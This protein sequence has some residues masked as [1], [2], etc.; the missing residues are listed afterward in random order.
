MSSKYQKIES[1]HTID[2]IDTNRKKGIDYEFPSGTIHNA[3]FLATLTGA[4]LDTVGPGTEVTVPP[5][6]VEKEKDVYLKVQPLLRFGTSAN[7]YAY[8]LLDKT[9]HLHVNSTAMLKLPSTSQQIKIGSSTSQTTVVPMHEHSVIGSDR[10]EYE[11]I[12][13]A[14][15][16]STHFAV[17]FEIQLK[18]G[19]VSNTSFAVDKDNLNISMAHFESVQIGDF[20][21]I[22]QGDL[23][24]ETP[25]DMDIT[26]PSN[27]DSPSKF[28]VTIENIPLDENDYDTEYA[29]RWRNQHDP[30]NTFSEITIIRIFHYEIVKDYVEFTSPDNKQPF[31][32]TPTVKVNLGNIGKEELEIE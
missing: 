13:T 5:L 30:D 26:R 28:N 29:F 3:K 21:S 14:Q 24:W 27:N 8:T 11:G 6:A 16:A 19:D 12:G 15:G 4:A 22:S 9:L 10:I 1:I 17:T 2:F 32:G 7:E 31:V 23:F 20:S 18:S 25:I